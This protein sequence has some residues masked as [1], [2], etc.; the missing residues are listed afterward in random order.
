MCQIPK[1][2]TKNIFLLKQ[3]ELPTRFQWHYMDM[4]YWMESSVV[5]CGSGLEERSRKHR[6]Y[7]FNEY[8]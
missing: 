4:M 3:L 6:L 8:R 5:S 1:Y 2:K 7:G